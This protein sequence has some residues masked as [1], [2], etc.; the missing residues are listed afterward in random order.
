MSI[1]GGAG[2][3]KMGKDA[4]KMGGNLFGKGGGSGSGPT[5]NIPKFGMKKTEEFMKPEARIVIGGP[6]GGSAINRRFNQMRDMAQNRSNAANTDLG[7][8]IKRKFASQ[9][10]SGSGAEIAA[11]QKAAQ[12]NFDNSAA[13]M[14]QLDIAESQELGNRELA[15]A[16]M[17]FK[18]RV[19]SFDKASKMHE[20][21]LAE[22]QQQIDSAATEYNAKL[23]QE[24]AKPQ[25][26]GFVSNLID[27]IF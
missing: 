7:N 10:L 17:D 2:I 16:D 22:R 13:Q 4:F 23:S 18:Q 11:M 3:M 8:A 19:F 14:Q 26:K 24:M 6:G 20:L 5:A 27:G 25:K 15:Q 1:W 12:S 21:D 9:G